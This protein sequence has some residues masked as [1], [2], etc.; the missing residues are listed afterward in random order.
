LP[1]APRH[2]RPEAPGR[3]GAGG[4]GAR[5]FPKFPLP[6][7]RKIAPSER[8]FPRAAESRAG[9]EWS[10][11]SHWPSREKWRDLR[12][13]LWCVVPWFSGRFVPEDMRAIRTQRERVGKPPTGGKVCSRGGAEARRGLALS[14]PPGSS[15]AAARTVL[16]RLSAERR[17]NRP[18][19]APSTS[20]RTGSAPPREINPA[21]GI[22]RRQ[23]SARQVI[24]IWITWATGGRHGFGFVGTM[25]SRKRHEQAAATWRTGEKRDDHAR[26]GAL[27]RR[28]RLRSGRAQRRNGADR[29][30]FRR[31]A[32]RRW[33]LLPIRF[34]CLDFAVPADER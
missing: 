13:G 3:P 12:G 5:K 20:L 29:S 16:L 21:A 23:A 6:R 7:K 24:L 32:L 30:C 34:F 9:P 26:D 31:P 33:L 17:P 4:S 19:R 18:L 1:R 25:E 2:S 10:Q 15:S 22:A 28:Q 27:D 11:C 8:A 14:R